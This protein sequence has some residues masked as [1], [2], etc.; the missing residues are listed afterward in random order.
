VPPIYLLSNL[1]A[2]DTKN[3]GI[4]MIKHGVAH[5]CPKYL[6]RGKPGGSGDEHLAENMPEKCNGCK[7]RIKSEA[8][9]PKRGQTGQITLLS[10]KHIILPSTQHGFKYKKPD[11]NDE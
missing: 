6:R 5:R 7:R 11:S 4:G 1:T 2:S 10:F 9:C 8:P 3:N